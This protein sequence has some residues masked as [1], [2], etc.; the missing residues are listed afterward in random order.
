MP[1]L[2]AAIEAV[3]KRHQPEK[4]GLDT[5]CYSCYVPSR[6]RSDRVPSP[7]PCP[8]VRAITTALAGTGK[9]EGS[10]DE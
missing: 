1:L 3:L 9:K 7:W 6:T 4:L 2:V 5:V 10:E 8:E